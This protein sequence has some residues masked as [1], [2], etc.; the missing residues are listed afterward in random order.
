MFD[1]RCRRGRSAAAAGATKREVRASW[2]ARGPGFDGTL[3]C[4]LA[5]YVADAFPPPKC[6]KFFGLN[7]NLGLDQVSPRPGL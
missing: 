6:L 7:P 5:R 4:D 3:D 1:E 2:K